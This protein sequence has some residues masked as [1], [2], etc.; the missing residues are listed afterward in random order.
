MLWKGGRVPAPPPSAPIPAPPAK[1]A[2][3]E[4][5]SDLFLKSDADALAALAPEELENRWRH[6]EA[7][8]QACLKCRLHE[9]R[10][11]VVFGEG[12]LRARLVFVGEG[13]GYEEDQSGRPFV[14][15]AG[16]LLDKI[17]SAMGLARP[18]VYICNVVKCR[19]PENRTPAP[20]EAAACWPY[21][22]EQ[23]MLLRPK[24]IVALGSPAAKTLLRTSEGITSLRGQ[25][26][27]WRGIRVMPTYH[28]AFV[29]RQYTPTIRGQ[30]W[31]DMRKV[32]EYLKE[33]G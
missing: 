29:L 15:R 22:E 4:A 3:V 17:I 28:P 10:T 27:E 20:E 11:K 19:P 7:R 24:V 25:W 9:V 6:L 1:T 14:G 26:R 5:G 32:A 33:S 2:P 31:E 23:L 12:D 16:Q 30:V 21:L 8:A 13:P 18:A